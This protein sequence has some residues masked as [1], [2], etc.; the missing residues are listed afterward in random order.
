MQIME[1]TEKCLVPVTDFRAGQEWEDGGEA[2]ERARWCCEQLEE[3]HILY[4]EELPYDFPEEDRK[5]LI[6]QKL[7]DSRLHKNISYRPKQDLLRGF[8]AQDAAAARRLHEVLRHYSENVIRF[9]TQLLAPYSSG[10]TID[11]ASFRPEAEQSRNL[12]VRKRNDLLHVD[13]FP[14]RPTRGGRILRCFTN[15]NPTEG[16]VWNTTD[17]F[18][19]LARDHAE[20]AGLKDFAARGGPGVAGAFQ[21]FG[22][23]FGLKL[24]SYSAYDKFMLHFH[25]YMKENSRFQQE[26]PKIKLEFP[27]GSTWIC[28]TDSVPHAVLYGQ[29]AVEQTLIIP[30]SALVTPEKSPLRILEKQAG[31]AMA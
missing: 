5:F 2:Q 8:A 1:T 15:I 31:R 20:R 30:V 25:D 16:R 6:S 17:A 22:R 29:H 7:G 23:A 21:S 13:A 12:P 3:S 28:F 9:L 14:S 11:Y 4:F 18:P 19:E 24:K 26:C 27:P 10:W